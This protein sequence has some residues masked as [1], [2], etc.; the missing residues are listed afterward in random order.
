MVGR[1]AYGSTVCVRYVQLSSIRMVYGDRAVSSE[2]YSWLRVLVN[3]AHVV[4]RVRLGCDKNGPT[5]PYNTV[6]FRDM[7]PH[8][9]GLP[10]PLDPPG[11]RA[12]GPGGDNGAW[13]PPP[14]SAWPRQRPT[15]RAPPSPSDSWGGSWGI[16]FWVGSGILGAGGLGGGWGGEAGVA[17]FGFAAV[18]A[19]V[20]VVFVMAVVC[21]AGGGGPRPPCPRPR[22]HPSAPLFARWG[23]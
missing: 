1:E 23:L 14:G 17:A 6:P 8:R 10:A 12:S 7:V 13:T 20:V 15:A 11:P 9:G 2:M 21:V 5:D 18:V 16:C 3:S 22:I 4:P 19:G